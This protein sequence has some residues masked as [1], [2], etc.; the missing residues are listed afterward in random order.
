MERPGWDHSKLIE[1]SQ[2]KVAIVNEEDY[3]SL[4]EF[5]W[6]AAERVSTSGLW[7]AVRNLRTSEGRGSILMHRQILGVTDR[8]IRIDHIEHGEFGGL[9][10]RR[11]NLRVSDGSTNIANSRKTHSE[12]SSKYKGV[13][14]EN[15][16]GKW[17]AK[18]SCEGNHMWLGRF[19]NEAE[20][21]R[22]YDQKAIELFGEFALVNFRENK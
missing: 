6:S 21:A 19:V 7:Y 1:L 9:D 17:R 10:N 22:A 8:K 16:S 20:A 11:A 13:H 18:V 15:W 14:W 3:A 5:K 2:G 4:V 12:T